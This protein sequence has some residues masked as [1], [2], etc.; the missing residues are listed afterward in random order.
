MGYKL[1]LIPLFI[2]IICIILL[3][4]FYYS[5]SWCNKLLR[6]KYDDRHNGS[7]N[8]ITSDKKYVLFVDELNWDNDNENNVSS[9]SLRF[10]LPLIYEIKSIRI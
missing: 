1:S 9:L 3:L 5:F 7:T 4:N 2:A 6:S 10:T 8:E